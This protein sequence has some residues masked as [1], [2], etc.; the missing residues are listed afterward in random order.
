MKKLLYITNIPSPY[1]V[2]FWNELGKH[3]N[4]TV[5][6]ES[7]NES[8]REWNI[9]GMGKNFSY[10]FLKSFTIGLDNHVG[11]E[12]LKRLNKES[13]DIYILGSYSS[14]TEMLAI[15]WFKFR[16]KKFFL[17]SDGGFPK[18]ENF[19]KKGIKRFF[20]SGASYWLCAGTNCYNYLSYYGAKKE[21]ISQYPFASVDY[22]KD[23]LLPL[24]TVEREIFKKKNNFKSRVILTVG[25]L[26]HRK[27]IDVLIRAFIKR[28]EDMKDVS[29]VIIG[30][31]DEEK[32]Y[33]ELAGECVGDLNSNIIFRSFMQMK[34]LVNF[35]KIADLFV[36]PTRYDIWGLVINEA[37]NFGLPVIATDMCGAAKDLIKDGENG[38]TV[39]VENI[40]IL[41]DKLVEAFSDSERL[42]NF[43]KKSR[44]IISGYTINKMVEA[45][46]KAIECT[47]EN[48][49][50]CTT[51]NS[52]GC[53]TKSRS[54]IE[55][56]GKCQ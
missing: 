28:R 34:E 3:Y 13:F 36:L 51:E 52:T 32:K 22:Q 10:I 8:N 56:E 42:K 9:D 45:H 27:G 43:G 25:Q 46:V 17:N 44:E 19:I 31:G 55:R 4:V 37:M 29:L 15:M 14:V 12:V 47:T 23:E 49:I 21:L 53:G 39:P 35:Y 40:D 38:Y 18:V 48:S 6:F 26:I 24:D 30:S 33:K 1:R 16:N 11:V 5:W 54:S 41:G 2:E 50:E 20:I 7:K